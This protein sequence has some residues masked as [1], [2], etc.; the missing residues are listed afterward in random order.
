MT[1]YLQQ[2][3]KKIAT[4]QEDRRSYTEFSDLRSDKLSFQTAGLRTQCKIGDLHLHDQDTAI[5]YNTKT[6]SV[7][8]GRLVLVVIL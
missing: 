3:H 4:T 7:Q 1:I 5:G 6:N 8:H 2:P